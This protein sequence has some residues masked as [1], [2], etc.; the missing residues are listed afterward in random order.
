MK[1][2]YML[3]LVCALSAQLRQESLNLVEL[4]TKCDSIK[5]HLLYKDPQTDDIKNVYAVI[6]SKSFELYDSPD[7]QPLQEQQRA[8]QT[9]SL[10]QMQMEDHHDQC[11]TLQ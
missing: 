8:K 5:G 1:Y 10:L 7:A 9:F 6:S 4:P 11:F 3:T 2:F